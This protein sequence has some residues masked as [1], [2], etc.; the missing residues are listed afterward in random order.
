MRS[1]KQPWYVSSPPPHPARHGERQAS[2]RRRPLGD[3]SEAAGSSQRATIRSCTHSAAA[4]WLQWL[5][6]ALELIRLCWTSQSVDCA[7]RSTAHA[8][9]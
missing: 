9:P 7:A 4:E 5:W 3:G 8:A 6:D 1:P 2:E